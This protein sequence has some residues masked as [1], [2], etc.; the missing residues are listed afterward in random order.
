MSTSSAISTN[1]AV[2]YSKKAYVD[3]YKQTA[4]GYGVVKGII[5]ETDE[6]K[7][8]RGSQ[9]NFAKVS[10]LSGI[11]TSSD[12]TLFGNEESIRN[13]TQTMQVQEFS[14]AVS[15]PTELKIERQETYIEWDTIANDLLVGFAAS[16]EDA[17]FFQQLAG[18]YSTSI[19]VDG[20][21]YSGADRTHV[22]G[23]NAII[24]PTSNRLIIAAGRAN[25][26]SLTSSDTMTLDYVDDAIALLES[27]Y[28]S[29]E[30]DDEGF[31]HLFVS[32]QQAKDLIQDSSGRAQLYTIGLNQISGGKESITIFDSGFSGN[33]A[34]RLIGT[35][36]NVKIWQCKRVAKG[37]NS[38]TSAEV[39][40]AQRAVLCGKNAV[41]YASYYGKFKNDDINTVPV[42][43]SQQLSDY[44]RFKGTSIHMIDG[45][46]KNQGLL[47]SGSF[48]DQAVVVIS[49][50]GA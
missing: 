4:L 26:Q 46:I 2:A 14:H 5:N 17:G 19:S 25:D 16:R 36:R 18:A 47:A 10:L 33:K 1:R 13:D 49:T 34:M 29:A 6:L 27:N 38:S 24:A 39:P 50:Y 9:I 12:G 22:T 3:M 23:R 20:A 11:G 21:S 32:P 30:T 48:E 40:L 44:G 45:M 42:R 37:V 8:K 28:P 7:G 35:Y 15:N 31:L 43:M 41:T